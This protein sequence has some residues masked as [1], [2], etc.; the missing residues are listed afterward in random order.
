MNLSPVDVAIICAY[1]LLVLGVGFYLKDKMRT[2]ADFLLTSHSLPHWITGIAFMSAN[3]GPLEV[4]AEIAH[5]VKSGMRTNLR[6]WTG[7]I[8]ALMFL[9]IFM[10]R[11]Y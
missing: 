5:V 6:Y 10:V 2:S 11:Y 7:A 3:L 4:M 9:G 8:P 1:F